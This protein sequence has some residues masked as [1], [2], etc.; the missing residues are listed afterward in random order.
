M[1]VTGKRFCEM[2]VR[3]RLRR[4]EERDSAGAR[5]DARDLFD[6]NDDEARHE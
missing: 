2:L 3:S 6:G 5:I 1:S 4:V